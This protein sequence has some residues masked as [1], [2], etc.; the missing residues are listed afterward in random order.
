MSKFK[1]VLVSFPVSHTEL[2]YLCQEDVKVG[3]LVYVPYGK[4]E[5]V[6]TVIEVAYYTKDSLPN[7]LTYDMLKTAH[8]Y[9]KDETIYIENNEFII[10]KENND[11][12]LLNDMPSKENII[13]TNRRNK[14]YIINPEYIKK[15]TLDELPVH[16]S[17][18]KAAYLRGKNIVFLPITKK[19]PSYITALIKVT[20]FFNEAPIDLLEDNQI[21]CYIPKNLAPKIGDFITFNNPYGF[22]IGEVTDIGLTPKPLST[23]LMTEILK[24][25]PSYL[26]KIR[27][28]ASYFYR[29]IDKETLT[30]FN[31]KSN[32]RIFYFENHLLKSGLVT[33]IKKFDYAPKNFLN[34][35]YGAYFKKDVIFNEYN[36]LSIIVTMYLGSKIKVEDVLLKYNE[37]KE[38]CEINNEVSFLYK[39]CF[40]DNP[41]V[42]KLIINSHLTILEDAFKD[43]NI[44]EVIIRDTINYQSKEVFINSSI[45]KLVIPPNLSYLQ[46][47]LFDTNIDVQILK[48]YIKEGNLILSENKNVLFSVT[49]RYL[50]ELKIPSSVFVVSPFALANMPNLKNLDLNFVNTLSDKALVNTPNLE[51]ITTILPKHL[52]LS[53]FTEDLTD[54]L[55]YIT[56]IKFKTPKIKDL[57]AEK[58]TK[59]EL[60]SYEDLLN[61]YHNLGLK[62]LPFNE[63]NLILELFRHYLEKPEENLLYSIYK[64]YY[65]PTTY[66]EENVKR[67]I[68]NVLF[69]VELLEKLSLYNLI[70]D[71]D[72]ELTLYKNFSY[73]YANTLLIRIS[74]NKVKI[75]TNLI[76]KLAIHYKR[77]NEDANYN[78][79]LFKAFVNSDLPF[80]SNQ[81]RRLTTIIQLDI[82]TVDTYLWY[83]LKYKNY[84]LLIKC[85]IIKGENPDNLKTF[86]Q[87]IKVFIDSND[88]LKSLEFAKK[89]TANLTSN[90]LIDEVYFEYFRCYKSN[91]N[92]VEECIK[93]YEQNTLKAYE[94]FIKRYYDLN[95]KLALC[96]ATYYYMYYKRDDLNTLHKLYELCLKED[97][98]NYIECNRILID[99]FSHKDENLSFYDYI[100][101]NS[102]YLPILKKDKTSIKST[103]NRRDILGKL[104][105]NYEVLLLDNKIIT[106]NNEEDIYNY[107][108]EKDLNF[109]NLDIIC[110]DYLALIIFTIRYNVPSL[111][112]NYKKEFSPQATID[113]Y[114]T[115]I[116]L[117]EFR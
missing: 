82:T 72:K 5:E 50:T 91:L 29:F 32:M 10:A 21:F 57:K 61:N 4:K 66:I 14:E 40:K 99:M 113:M 110:T 107:L 104:G 18:L 86:T 6:T 96:N 13:V 38:V 64:H 9:P 49:N 67:K 73:D 39:E 35:V 71:Y 115:D 8:L 46:E 93:D 37:N 81:F 45:H 23:F 80:N 43:S 36:E 109:P 41:Q 54:S 94:F 26:I 44:E 65:Y 3:D 76:D 53:A 112:Y 30:T 74:Q 70:I 95:D 102:I 20:F 87:D 19:K 62:S 83:A 90:I 33:D 17:K 79:N 100:T 60:L 77:Y 1:C 103:I 16:L 89:Y 15:L 108:K 11:Y 28:N 69:K 59:D 12:Y 34:I 92:T 52:F 63:T 68:Y 116:L 97:V 117:N 47:E 56:K 48:P 111:M 25:E 24:P 88:N 84:D 42:K 2:L 98:L 105:I 22:N 75:P 51:T 78:R 27:N 114:N 55:D 7:L 101:S 106:F 58:L 85:L 31:I